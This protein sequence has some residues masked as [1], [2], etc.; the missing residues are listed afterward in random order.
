MAIAMGHVTLS[1]REFDFN[2]TKDRW[3]YA[4]E[5]TYVT[6]A[7]ALGPLYLPT[8]LVQ[9]G[10]VSGEVNLWACLSSNRN[11]IDQIHDLLPQEWIANE[12][13]RIRE[14]GGAP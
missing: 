1:T 10:L 14:P 4:H 12:L 2:V 13:A 8:Y 11:L 3:W 6:E 5:R 9:V 7:N